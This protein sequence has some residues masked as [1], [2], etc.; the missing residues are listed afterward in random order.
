MEGMWWWGGGR[1]SQELV[2]GRAGQQ[3]EDG[4]AA[5]ALPRHRD[6]SRVAAEAG[7]LL[8]HPLQRAD[9]VPEAAV[10]VAVLEFRP[11]QRAEA[12]VDAAS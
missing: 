1:G 12:V 8:L 9:L 2:G 7:N 6:V 3:A 4:G 11:A 5:R 10:G